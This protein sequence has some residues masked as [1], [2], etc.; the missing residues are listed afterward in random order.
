ME[1]VEH[2][3]MP[4]FA[5]T[6]P[7][8]FWGAADAQERANGRTYTEIQFA[9]PRELSR[10]KQIE[11]A[12]SAT[13]EFLGDRHAYTLAV[14]APDAR[15]G[16]EQPHA[17]LMFSERRIDERTRE[18]PAEQFFKRNGAT[19]DRAWNDKAKPEELREKWCQMMNQAMRENHVESQVDHRS[20]E[21][22][23]REDLSRCASRRS[24]TAL[25]L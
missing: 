13:K 1:H 12:H 24:A 8:Q 11:L 23:G 25:M 4:V 19:K 6:E 22:Q 17:H 7:I 20:Y 9:L 10:E 21:R 15:D 18:L 16:K 14:H 2:G 3:N 5:A